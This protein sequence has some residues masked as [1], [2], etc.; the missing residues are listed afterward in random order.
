MLN[1]NNNKTMTV[2][3]DTAGGRESFFPA[4]KTRKLILSFR[5]EHY[6]NLYL[7]SCPG[8]EPLE[9]RW[10]LCRQGELHVQRP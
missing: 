2:K 7:W 9:Q 5:T 3:R 10:M 6:A 8:K 1:N 4:F